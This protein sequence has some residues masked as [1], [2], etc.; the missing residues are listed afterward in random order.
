MAALLALDLAARG[1]TVGRVVAAAAIPALI[2]V[3]YFTFSRGSSLA[4]FAGVAVLLAIA[5]RR[6]QLIAASLAPAALAAV[7]VWR[8][9]RE[10]ALTHTSTGTLQAAAHQGHHLALVLI[11]LCL[12]RPSR[13][14]TRS[15]PA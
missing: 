5:E 15:A 10:G 3:V 4:L 2:P 1:K 6:V 8:A 7:A 12:A 13:S 11:A 14:R 9:S